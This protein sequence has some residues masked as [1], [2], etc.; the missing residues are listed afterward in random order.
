MKKY[1]CLIAAVL[2]ASTMAATAATT[3]PVFQLRLVA[4]APTANSEPMELIHQNSQ[5]TLTNILNIDKTVLLD[6]TALKS[7]TPTKDDLG[8]PVISL[9]FTDA[10]AKQFAE[11]TRQNVHHQLAI[12]IDGRLCEAPN[13]MME[14]T[15]GQAEISGKFTKKETKDLAAQISAAL[16]RQ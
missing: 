15:G 13:I 10:G 5:G 4:D 7:A 16:A 3:P 1:M 2:F 12:I 9:V 14:I 11:V 6:Q 8:Q